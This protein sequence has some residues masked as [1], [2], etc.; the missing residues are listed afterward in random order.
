VLGADLPQFLQI[1]DR[2]CDHARRALHRLD[3]DRGDGR[4]V[5]KGDEPAELVG[6][7]RAPGRHPAR[8]RHLGRI[9]RMRQM[10]DAGKLRRGKHLAV[11]DHP[12]DRDA[13]EAD[14]VIAALAADEAGAR[15]LALHAVVSERDLQR[16]VD[17]LGARVDEEHV[18]EPVRRHRGDAVG[19]PERARVTHLER[20]AVVDG[21]ELAL[22]CRADARMRVTEAHAP[23]PVQTIEQSV[24]LDRPVVRALRTCEQAM[25]GMPLEVAVVREGHPVRIEVGGDLGHALGDHFVH[26]GS[27]GMRNYRRRGD[28]LTARR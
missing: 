1:A 13:A 5:V 9:V 2:R 21:L 22:E 3:D 17:R 26:G 7:V 11:G 4:R 23:K 6:E 25:C 15:G 27:P 12:A 20:R 14:A 8:E 16:G 19:E 24:A 18:I 28:H 10:V